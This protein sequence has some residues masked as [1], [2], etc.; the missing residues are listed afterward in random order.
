MLPHQWYFCRPSSHTELCVARQVSFTLLRSG[1]RGFF[2]LPI[3]REGVPEVADVS[4]WK[5]WP[6]REE[7]HDRANGPGPARSGVGPRLRSLL[8]RAERLLS[9]KSFQ[10]MRDATHLCSLHSAHFRVHARQRIH[11]RTS[12][13]EKGMRHVKFSDIWHLCEASVRSSQGVAPHLLVPG[14][15]KKRLSCRSGSPLCRESLPK[16]M[17]LV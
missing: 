7:R 14:L 2:C 13:G 9:L 4:L 15:A 17:C 8:S 16:E 10:Y 6:V 1:R 5:S 12:H 11:A 3:V